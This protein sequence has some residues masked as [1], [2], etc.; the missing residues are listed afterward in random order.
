LLF[1]SSFLLLPSCFLL[2]ASCFSLLTGTEYQMS[3][4]DLN[5]ACELKPNDK[6]IALLRDNLKKSMKQQ[7][8]KDKQ[9]FAG[10]FNRGEIVKEK[11]PEQKK[12][13]I[14]EKKAQQK[15][16][17]QKLIHLANGWAAKGKE[18]EKRG[19]V[20]LCFVC[21][22]W[23]CIGSLYRSIALLQVIKRVRQK[24]WHKPQKFVNIWNNI[25]KL[26]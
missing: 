4:N 20:L 10:M 25:V 2:L 26:V 23:F 19:T 5:R 21:C 16:D 11:K 14:Q 9:Q 18:L 1:A 15:L 6:A 7:N 13:E 17:F 8:V 3:L 12:K 24:R 22:C